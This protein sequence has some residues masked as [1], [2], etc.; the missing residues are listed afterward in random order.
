MTV[1]RR[2]RWWLCVV[3]GAIAGVFLGAAA[4]L[5]RVALSDSPEIAF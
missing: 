2:R 3:L 1:P 4:A 5:A